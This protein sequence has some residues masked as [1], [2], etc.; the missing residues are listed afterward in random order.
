MSD[1]TPQSFVPFL[2][3]EL[4]EKRAML[5]L[6]FIVNASPSAYWKLIGAFGSAKNGLTQHQTAWQDLNIHQTHLDRFK[7]YVDK[8]LPDGFLACLSDI[9]Q[10][11]YDVIFCLDDWY[12][13]QLTQLTD[14]PPLLFIKGNKQ[15]LS[16]AQVAIVGTRKASA[17]AKKIAESFAQ[18]LA[19][20]GLW[21]T[22]GLADGIDRHAHIGALKAGMPNHISTN[23]INTNQQINT[24]DQ[25]TDKKGRTLAVLGSGI[26]ICYPKR[27]KP[28]YA[29]IIAEGGAIITEFLPNMQPLVHNFPRR[30]R[31]VSC[32]SLATLVVEAALKSGSLITAR[33]AA[34][35]G[36]LVFAIP[37][38]IYNEQAKGCH[39]LI[40]EGAILVDS[41]EQI[42]E[43]INLPRRLH[44]DIQT[45]Q[46]SPSSESTLKTDT[47]ATQQA[48]HQKPCQTETN[49]QL[50][51]ALNKL[52]LQMDWVGQDMDTLINITQ[53]DVADLSGQLMELELHG[54]VM[55][56]G[57]LY[58]RCRS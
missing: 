36:K 35:Q 7:H 17:S 1:K 50:S 24:T 41:P 11:K 23:Q 43:D 20:E 42:I 3:K 53:L 47:N 37:S 45:E 38:H 31:I 14:K 4:S 12:P 6:W 8:Q 33:H 55:Q 34:E 16:Q 5:L 56:Q 57:G 27:N 39:Y 21:I 15:V 48:P 22:S 19:N 9:T 13:K 29:Q 49:N 26:E 30:N 46:T 51:D 54:L 40:R 44:Q 10:K 25:K 28:L 58:M 32:L 2:P 18:Y 52:L